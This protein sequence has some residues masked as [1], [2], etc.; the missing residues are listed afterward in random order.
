MGVFLF[1]IV[2]GNLGE[3]VEHAGARFRD[4]Q[5]RKSKLAQFIRHYNIDKELGK[6]MIEYFQYRWDLGHGFDADEI[7]KP[8]PSCIG[9]NADVALFL[10]QSMLEKVQIFRKIS[11][12]VLAE[13]AKRLKMVTVAP[14][15]DI[16]KQ[17]D[18]PADFMC[19]ISHGTFDVIVD[20]LKIS[21]LEERQHFGETALFS[22][23]KRSHTFRA[24]RFC[25]VWI[26][27]TADFCEVMSAYPQETAA[28]WIEVK[29]KEQRLI[30]HTTDVMEER[31]ATKRATA[32]PMFQAGLAKASNKYK[33]GGIATS[34]FAEESTL[35]SV[36]DETFDG[37][38]GEEDTSNHVRFTEDSKTVY[39]I[40]LIVRTLHIY[41]ALVI[42][43][44]IGFRLNS[45]PPFSIV[46]IDLVADVYIILWILVHFNVSIS[47]FGVQVLDRS[48]IQQIY[49]R[50]WFFFDI[51]TILPLNLIDVFNPL[52]RL[53]RFLGLIRYFS[54]GNKSATN[55]QKSNLWRLIAALLTCLILIHFVSC[56]YWIHTFIEGYGS[57]SHDEFLPPEF[58]REA[59][60]F[61][62]Y[63][64]AT[65]FSLKALT[66]RGNPFI[67]KTELQLTFALVCTMLGLFGVGFVI[68]NIS[69][70]VIHMNPLQGQ[71][72][73]R[74]GDTLQFMHL[75]QFP[76][77]LQ[78]R[79][80]RY[81][82]YRWQR[83]NG[84][85]IADALNELPL[86]LEKRVRKHLVMKHLSDLPMFK[87]TSHKVLEVLMMKVRFVILPP[88][89]YLYY[90][91][92]IG[93][94]LF[95][96]AEGAVM[97]ELSDGHKPFQFNEGSF[98]GEE[99]ILDENG[100]RSST[101]RTLTSSTFLAFSV[102]ALEDALHLESK[103]KGRLMRGLHI[104][105]SVGQKSDLK[106]VSFHERHQLFVLL[107][108]FAHLMPLA[109][110]YR[111]IG[112]K[113]NSC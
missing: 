66:G 41:N 56:G 55:H 13:I 47:Q 14:N 58:L 51:L 67:P 65:L 98:I 100:L 68:G 62:Q 32:G 54:I 26:L 52:W 107:S 17:G 69:L 38:D 76:V 39:F 27:M 91:G 34:A 77:S 102:S 24:T 112:N 49:L 64:K 6:D 71:H 109:N 57:G 59:G 12:V 73:H 74:V 79:V 85:S 23:E 19:F 99:A 33:A 9:L 81:L 70:L 10:A 61:D 89:E 5:Q 94:D 31:R 92:Q 45:F 78:M 11:I 82:D 86:S 16:I 8:I 111:H 90:E 104:R 22:P 106:E 29:K 96:I 95:I 18:E 63:V 60:I 3:V 105:Q 36:L 48:E 2:I 103:T 20:D 28:T 7:K 84:I 97:M 83:E 1:A 35:D 37:L 113:S 44:L 43:T 15:E 72:K 53:P 4:H 80:L 101:I 30:K 108:T 50:S 75:K 25:E 21:T 46:V 110:N 40:N 93:D 42:S 87:H 88:D